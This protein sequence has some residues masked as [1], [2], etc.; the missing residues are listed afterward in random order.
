MMRRPHARERGAAL[1]IGLIMLVLISLMLIAALNVGMTNFRSVSNMQ[2]R[3]EAIAAA[4]AAIQQRVSSTTLM[5]PA[6]TLS[7]LDID[8]DGNTDYDVTVTPVCVN[9]FK[10]FTAPPSSLSLGPGMS[11]SPEWS[12]TWDITATATDA[13]TGVSVTVNAGVRVQM[14]DTDRNT[15]C[16]K[17]AGEPS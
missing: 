7:H 6:V 14:G 2:Y 1:V 5:S 16:P 4:N 10:V 17:L 3:E 15:N 13:R 9:A 8:N 12:T 11:V